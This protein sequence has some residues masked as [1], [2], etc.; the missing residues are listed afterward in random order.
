VQAARRTL[1][2]EME[3]RLAAVDPPSLERAL[4][5]ADALLAE[6]RALGVWPPADPLGG[7]EV[8]VRVA[9]AL[10]SVR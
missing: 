2:P 8:D 1:L 9:G 6:G 10:R 3:A 5:I 7:I 4:Q